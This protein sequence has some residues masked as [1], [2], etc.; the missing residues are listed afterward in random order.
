MYISIIL[1]VIT[2]YINF[3]L[4]VELRVLVTCIRHPDVHN[5]IYS[6]IFVRLLYI[7]VYR[8]PNK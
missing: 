2:M 1:N 4:D 3:I 7:F 6:C 5:F 8:K